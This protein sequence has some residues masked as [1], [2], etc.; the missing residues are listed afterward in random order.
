M[1]IAT[2]LDEP[3]L[4]QLLLRLAPQ[5]QQDQ[6]DLVK[7]IIP[8]NLR[9][10]L[11]TLVTLEKTDPHVPKKAEAKAAEGDGNRK[12]K[13]TTQGD[14][15]TKKKSRSSKHCEL[16]KKHGGAK[17]T[18]NTVDCKRYE[19]DGTQKKAFQPR[20][21]TPN[22]T[23]D[24]KSYNTVKHELKEAK[25]ELKKIKKTS[26]KSKK[27]DRDDSSDNTNSS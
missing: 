15:T 8:V 10:T 16:C 24:C 26:H 17:N 27:R 21:G 18:H 14:Q 19:K 2:A 11:D 20:K 3:E 9:L 5:S 23:T 25:S 6:F 7:G 13:G 22:K 12:R 1:K 4:A